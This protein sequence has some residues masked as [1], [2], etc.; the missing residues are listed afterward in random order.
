MPDAKKTCFVVM[1]FGKK[2]DY[3]TS[4]V[5]DLDKSYQYI[6]KPAAEDAGLDCKR[7]DE[8]IHSGLIDVPMYDQLLMADV[9][10]ADIST[11]NANAFYELGVRHA[12][13]PYTTI[14]IAE[15]KMTFPFDVS[16]LAVRKYHHLG[17]GIDFGEVVR[18]KTE[19]TKAIQTILEKPEKDSPVYAF[20]SD[21]DPPSRRKIERAV[22]QSSPQAVA[23]AAADASKPER[24]TNPTMSVLMAQANEAIARSDFDTA[25]TLLNAVRTMAP[26]DP[27]VLQRLALATYKSKKPNALEALKD[28]AAILAEL[29][30]ER[31]ADTETLGLWGAIHKRV[32]D[33]TRN[34]E[35]LN[36]SIF[37]YEKGFY[38]KN[39]YYNGINLA[40]LYDLRAS[41]ST[42]A[43]AT[44]D[45][46]TAQRTRKRVLAICENL[47]PAGTLRAEDKYWVLATMAEAYTGLREEAKAQDYLKQAKSL[48]QPNWMI[49]S[50]DEQLANLKKLLSTAILT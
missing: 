17:E 5:L 32:W 11:S 37:A 13:R 14:T 2:T 40:Y 43:D 27:Y 18:M 15:D 48:D 41:L 16:H 36:T 23:A 21:L 20:F 49:E 22:A 26:K 39:D 6:I 50:T 1:G 3:Q 25:K 9:V 42:G 29:A 7:A 24:Q 12:L 8:I 47:L 33:L 44:A 45:S 30:P 19:L 34:R 10:I 35:N 38:L 4:R 46:I 31:S 28:S